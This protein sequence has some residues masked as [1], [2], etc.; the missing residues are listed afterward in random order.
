MTKM[1]EDYE[2]SCVLVKTRMTELNLQLKKLKNEKNDA[3]IASLD[4]KRRISLLYTEYRQMQEIIG[5]ISVYMR[6]N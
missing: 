2:K 1:I 3:L 4:L 6:R 5:T